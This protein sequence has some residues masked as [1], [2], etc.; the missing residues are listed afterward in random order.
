MSRPGEVEFTESA[1]VLLDGRLSARIDVFK[2][3]AVVRYITLRSHQRP[4]VLYSCSFSTE[5]QQ[6]DH[7]LSC[8]VLTQGLTKTLHTIDVR[9]LLIKRVET[10]LVFLKI[11]VGNGQIYGICQIDLKPAFK[12]FGKWVVYYE[13]V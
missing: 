7:S 9:I 6:I 12:I 5:P 10:F 13:G 3:Y 8:Q 1:H 2:V 4:V 11:T